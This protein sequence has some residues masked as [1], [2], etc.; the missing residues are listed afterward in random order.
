MQARLLSLFAIAALTWAQDAPQRKQNDLLMRD[1]KPVST[2]HVPEHQVLRAK[3]P[4]IDIHN[5]VNDSGVGGEE[6][7]DPAEVVRMMDQLN[8]KTIV[9]LTGGWGSALDKVVNEMVKPYPGR[10][11]AFTQVDW[12]RID[13]PNFGEAM[14]MQIR[15][16]VKHGARGLKVLK[17]LGLMVRDKS[18]KLVTIDDR[19]LD[20]IW[21]ECGRLHI[22]VAIHIADPEAFFRPIDN[23]NERYDEL[24]RHPDWSFCCPPKF[25]TLQELLDARD[26]VLARHPRTTFVLLH[27]GHWPENLDHVNRT[28]AR[29]PNAVIELG[30]RQAELGRQPRR[31]RALFL[32]Y[33]DRVLFG[34]DISPTAP[35]YRSYF[36]WLETD[37]E[38][39]DYF[40]APGQGFWKIS[41]LYLPD[42]VLRKVYATNAE[43]VLGRFHR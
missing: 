41:G 34:T 25:P 6:H 22:P 2:L 24:M 30:A 19:R 15:E 8:I 13:E 11:V 5:H 29:F 12:S 16:S 18:G 39:F 4:V 17:D 35:M 38:Y 33:P 20:P 3:F 31:A 27:V 40:G 42:D 32:K 37:D 28:L 23:T 21:A 7:R 36:R 10:F 1:Y 14:A 9:I 43:R 26:R